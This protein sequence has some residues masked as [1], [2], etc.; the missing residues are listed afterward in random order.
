MP[1]AASKR[2]SLTRPV[3]ITAVTSSMVME[4]SAT[5]VETTILATPAGGVMGAGECMQSG[6]WA[7]PIGTAQGL[8]F[9]SIKRRQLWTHHLW[10]AHR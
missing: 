3:S 1:R 9:V 5:L 2:I 4:V 8:R 10:Q 7:L 6:P